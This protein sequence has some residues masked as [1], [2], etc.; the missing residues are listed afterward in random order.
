MT[1]AMKPRRFHNLADDRDGNE[2]YDAWLA[3]FQAK[4]AAERSEIVARIE[5]RVH[6]RRTEPDRYEG[7]N[8]IP[9]STRYGQATGAIRVLD[10]PTEKQVAYLK[11]LVG[12]RLPETDWDEVV[13][14]QQDAG[15][16]TKR[17]AS[18][19]IETLKNLP[20]REAK[21]AA[22][23][24]TSDVPAG[25]YALPS[26]GDNDL[27]FYR[28]DRPTDGKWAGRVFVKM[29]VGGRAASNVR[30]DYQQ[31]ILDRIAEYGPSEAQ[32]LYGQE[33]GRCG[34]CNRHLTD[35]ESRR[36]GIGP[37]CRK[38]IEAAC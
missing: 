18:A 13:L 12:S 33:I 3:A 27:V 14:A 29:V 30:R 6:A 17:G 31:G 10:E 25:H 20:A 19:L 37:E 38:H 22:P 34:R 1:A 11:S 36:L 7:E 9:E 4:P 26:S 35:E 16:W 2:A 23:Q 8:D 15:T 28:V 32:V 5:T 24:V 21:P